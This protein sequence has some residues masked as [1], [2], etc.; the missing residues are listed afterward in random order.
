MNTS[1]ELI[2]I[3]E[4]VVETKYAKSTLAR[5][6]SEAGVTKVGKDIY[7]RKE[8]Y[9]LRTYKS[10]VKAEPKK[11]GESAVLRNKRIRENW[12]SLLEN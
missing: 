3:N 9:A 2:D 7:I 12:R 4:L 10:M 1:N 5:E 8:Y 11:F 6:L